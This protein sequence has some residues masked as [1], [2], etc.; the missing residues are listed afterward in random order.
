MWKIGLFLVSFTVACGGSPNPEPS[1]PSGAPAASAAPVK[2]AADG[3]AAGLGAG[4]DTAA[5]EKLTSEEATSGTCDPEHKAALDKLLDDAEKN[6]RAKSEDGA[7]LKIEYLTK[8]TL[9]LADAAKGVQL[10]LTGK[11][12]QVHV[13][14]FS[15]KEVSLDVLSGKEAATTMRSTY[16]GDLTTAS[17]TIRLPK[18]GGAVPLESDSRQIEMKPGASLEVRLRGH[19]CAGVIVFSKS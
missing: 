12:T 6:I 5:L 9:A 7:P 10:T 13:V 3:P 2:A 16:K 11:G 4:I 15:P 1:A 18:V 8:R 19:G 14:A 17:P